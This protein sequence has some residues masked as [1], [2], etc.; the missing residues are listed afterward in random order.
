MKSLYNWREGTK[1][2]RGRK[3]KDRRAKKEE[4][5]REKER[6][7]KRKKERRGK[8]EKMRDGRFG[9]Q[10]VDQSQSLSLS[11][12]SSIEGR[13]A[14]CTKE[15]EENISPCQPKIKEE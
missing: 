5:E 7:K 2:A 3:E 4:R 1:C 15:G 12:I 6:K 13:L 11:A 14:S 8:K 9:S 10:K